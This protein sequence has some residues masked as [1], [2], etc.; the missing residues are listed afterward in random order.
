MTSKR[1]NLLTDSIIL[2][3]ATMVGNVSN[4]L[5]QFIMSRS[6]STA[7][8]GILNSLLSLFIISSVPNATLIVIMARYISVFKANNEYEKIKTFYLEMMKQVIKWASIGLFIFLCLSKQISLYLNISSNISV[9]MVGILLW[10]YFL[11]PINQGMLQGLQQFHFLGISFGLSG[12]FRLI[13]AGIMVIG[14]ALGVNGA[15][16]G[17]IIGVL[18]VLIFTLIP[19][20]FL[21]NIET[22]NKSILSTRST[23]SVFFYSIPVLTATL[24]F[25]IITNID[26]I[27]VKHYFSPEDAGYYAAAAVLG[28]AILYLPTAIVLAIFP[29]VS[30]AHTLKGDTYIILKKA[31]YYTSLLSG[32]CILL[33]ILFPDILVGILFGKRYIPVANLVRMLG[34]AILPLVFVNIL[35]NFNMARSRMKFIYNMIL[36]CILEIISIIMFHTSLYHVIAIIGIV[37]SGL[38]LL[39]SYLVLQE[40]DVPIKDVEP[41]YLL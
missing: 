28:K 1:N 6:L 31:V 18:G 13:F 34:I 2:F 40:K 4:Y 21:V 41:N 23:D 17:S 9:M 37:G 14:F 20:R 5:F 27:L 22:S 16:I 8:Y 11:L 12:I 7:E 38:F 32:M 29:M 3:T 26:V 15:L 24:C 19:L 30:E 35:M 36:G 25:T 10:I 33:Y 39:N